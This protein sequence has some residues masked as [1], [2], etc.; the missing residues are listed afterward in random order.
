MFLVG[1][2]EYWRQNSKDGT[3]WCWFI[4]LCLHRETGGG[5]E[6]LKKQLWTLLLK[7]NYLPNHVPLPT[8]GFWEWETKADASLWRIWAVIKLK[9][10]FLHNTALFL[11]WSLCL[12]LAVKEA[13]SENDLYGRLFINRVFHITADK[14]FEILFTNS[15]FMQRFLNSR[16]IVGNILF[17]SLSTLPTLLKI[18]ASEKC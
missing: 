3:L 9:I 15:H 12:S 18:S 14:M 10:L 5:G 4:N 1:L 16:S 11:M 6:G 8:L 17:S 2:V 7:M 13:V